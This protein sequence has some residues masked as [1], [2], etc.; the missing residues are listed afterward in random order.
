MSSLCQRPEHWSQLVR[1][2]PLNCCLHKLL[3]IAMYRCIIWPSM[4]QSCYPLHPGTG[5]LTCPKGF[6]AVRQLLTDVSEDTAYTVFLGCRDVDATKRAYNAADL[7]IRHKLRC[8]PLELSRLQSVKEFAHEILSSLGGLHINTLLLCAA[9]SKGA[10]EQD[11]KDGKWSQAL[12]VNYA[13]PW[14]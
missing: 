12:I 8:F 6:E 3:L 1:L 5:I 9:I 11:Q 7:P 14:L 2:S 13:G 10:T 4:W